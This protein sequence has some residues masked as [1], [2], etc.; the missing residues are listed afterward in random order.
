MKVSLRNRSAWIAASVGA[1][2]FFAGA[3]AA[4]F[5]LP[6][7]VSIGIPLSSGEW[8]KMVDSIDYLKTEVDTL[9]T[10]VAV[11]KSKALKTFVGSTTLTYD[12]S[13]V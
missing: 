12:G 11:L 9:K 2:C 1:L 6:A 10:D 3:Y 5:S 7:K 13:G 8:N 4:T